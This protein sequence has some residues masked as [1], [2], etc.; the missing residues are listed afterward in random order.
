M[1]G[2]LRIGLP[3]PSLAD[4]S[5]ESAELVKGY[6]ELCSHPTVVAGLCAVCGKTVLDIRSSGGEAAASDVASPESGE[7]GSFDGSQIGVASSAA[8][9]MAGIMSRMT[10]SGGYTVSV[11]REEGERIAREDARRLRRIRKLS[12]VRSLQH[13]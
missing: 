2:I 4:L 13:Q 7:S 11:S 6:I 5:E 3:P 12:L 8:A 1:D 10:V 9:G